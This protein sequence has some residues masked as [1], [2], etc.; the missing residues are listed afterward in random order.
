MTMENPNGHSSDDMPEDQEFQF[1]VAGDPEEEEGDG[2]DPSQYHSRGGH[3]GLKDLFIGTDNKGAKRDPIDRMAVS[4]TNIEEYLPLT[5]LTPQELARHTRI[6][7]SLNNVNLGHSDPMHVLWFHWVGSIAI[8]GEG[9]KEMVTMVT[10][11][12]MYQRQQQQN[13]FQQMGNRARSPNT[14]MDQGT[15]E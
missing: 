2:G 3:P 15:G 11:D 4:S 5:R 14:N 13:R 10:A 7:A 8:N 1:P 12:R 9:R 6:I